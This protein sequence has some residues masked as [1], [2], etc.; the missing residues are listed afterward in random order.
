MKKKRLILKKFLIKNK[1]KNIVGYG[2][3]AK[4]TTLLNYLQ[5]SDDLKF[6]IDDNKLKQG[7]YIPGT[8]IKIVSKNQV[9]K[10]IDFLIVFVELL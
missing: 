2:A 3:A 4:T 9:N 7:H 6:I 5:I 1:N 10:D 8:K